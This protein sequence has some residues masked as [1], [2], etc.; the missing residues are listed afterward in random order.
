MPKIGIV[1]ALDGED[2]FV[3]AMKKAQEGAKQCDQELK[4]QGGSLAD[5][6]LENLDPEEFLKNAQ[7]SR[8][9]LPKVDLSKADIVFDEEEIEAMDDEELKS[10]SFVN[11][12]K[13]DENKED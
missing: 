2:K 8:Y 10:I 9:R 7:G 5:I 11:T 12:V 1:F 6:D 3:T 13:E 4:K